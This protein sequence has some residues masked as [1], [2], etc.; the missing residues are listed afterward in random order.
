[1]KQRGDIF[2]QNFIHSICNFRNNPKNNAKF[3]VNKYN[4]KRF[5][6]EI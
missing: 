6:M 5:L 3:Q 4:V 2:L 1:M